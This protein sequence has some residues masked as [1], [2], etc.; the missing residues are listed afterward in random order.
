MSNLPCIKMNFRHIWLVE[1]LPYPLK[2]H[3]KSQIRTP[4][5]G[6]QNVKIDHSHANV[7]MKDQIHIKINL[8]KK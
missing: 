3:C 5:S 1:K 8:D 4:L 6:G 7:G 2:N